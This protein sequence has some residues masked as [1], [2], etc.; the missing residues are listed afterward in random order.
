MADVLTSYATSSFL[1][2][3]RC[4]LLF[5]VERTTRASRFTFK[6]S[7][8][9]PLRCQL[10]STPQATCPPKMRT[11]TAIARNESSSGLVTRAPLRDYIRECLWG[12]ERAAPLSCRKGSSNMQTVTKLVCTSRKYSTSRQDHTESR[13]TRSHIFTTECKLG[14]QGYMKAHRSGG[15]A[16]LISH[17]S[18]RGGGWATPR[19]GR[20]TLCKEPRHPEVGWAPRECLYAS[21]EQKISFPHWGSNPELSSQHVTSCCTDCAVLLLSKSNI[22]TIYYSS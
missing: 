12:G 22:K 16:P 14:G 17:I 20:F 6:A 9:Q 1:H 10:E 11:A 19:S 21:G 15:T 4:M 13:L 2:R 7:N 8:G 5:S 18:A 3:T